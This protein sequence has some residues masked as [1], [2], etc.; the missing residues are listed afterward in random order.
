MNEEYT[1]IIR[2]ISGR[3][4]LQIASWK[5]YE[6]VDYLRAIGISQEESYL[7]GKWAARAKPGETMRS[8][9]LTFE[10]K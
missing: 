1:L 6:V 10:V 5:Y 9:K 7:V 2:D 3:K 4:K 8:G